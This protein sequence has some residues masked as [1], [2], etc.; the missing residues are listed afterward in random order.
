MF[1]LTFRQPTPAKR[2]TNHDRLSAS[3]LVSLKDTF[4]TAFEKVATINGAAVLAGVAR[5]THYNW[6]HKDPAYAAR[7]AESEEIA[8]ERLE[9]EARRRALDGVLEPVFY[10]GE[11]CGAI[12]KYDTA[13]T[14]FL[15]KARR[16]EV[17]RERFDAHIQVHQRVEPDMKAVVSEM[18]QDTAIE[19][20]ELLLSRL[21]IERDSTQRHPAPAIIDVTP[22]PE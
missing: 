16:P 7:F 13:L 8:T 10:Q 1:G 15:L 11:E 14:I 22:E 21:K 20:L 18:T 9:Q 3:Q 4:L 2:R 5:A 6:L 17:Y 12:R 19:R